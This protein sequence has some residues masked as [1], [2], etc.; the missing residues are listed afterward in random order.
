MTYRRRAGS[1]NEGGRGS[2][3]IDSPVQRGAEYQEPDER[4]ALEE[5]L[6]RL[7]RSAP[8]AS[9]CSWTHHV[10]AI[11]ARLQSDHAFPLVSPD[12]VTVSILRCEC[13]VAHPVKLPAGT[14]A[15]AAPRLPNDGGGPSLFFFGLR[16]WTVGVHHHRPAL[17]STA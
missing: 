7:V 12:N 13:N 2:E 3:D 8:R 1:G 15:K 10:T 9:I 6:R 17:T 16:G 11:A 4:V 5:A 14:G